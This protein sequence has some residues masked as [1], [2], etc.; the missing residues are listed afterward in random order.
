MTALI[1][2]GH[3]IST[4]FGDILIFQWSVRRFGEKYHVDLGACGFCRP[5]IKSAKVRN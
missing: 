2:L 1:G 5:E 4:H 3:I